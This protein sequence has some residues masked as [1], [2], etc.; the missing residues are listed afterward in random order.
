[1]QTA[2]ATCSNNVFI[3]EQ[4]ADVVGSLPGPAFDATACPAFG[5]LTSLAPLKPFL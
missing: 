1:M 5:I 2:E 4:Q 3:L